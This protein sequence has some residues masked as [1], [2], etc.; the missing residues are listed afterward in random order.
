MDKILYYDVLGFAKSSSF[1]FF[2]VICRARHFWGWG[3]G[4]TEQVLGLAY[5]AVESQITPLGPYP[6][7]TLP[8]NLSIILN[9][10][11]S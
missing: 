6:T 10:I 1:I 11:K 2:G 9:D 4:V 7:P 3:G 8:W 5:V